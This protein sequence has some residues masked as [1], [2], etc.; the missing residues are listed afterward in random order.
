[1][2]PAAPWA[3]NLKTLKD[4]PEW[5]FLSKEDL[6]RKTLQIFADKKSALRNCRNNEKV[7]KIPNSKVFIL[8]GKFLISKG[9][10]RIVFEE[11]LIS[12]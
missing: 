8:S 7:L 11:N 3:Q 9:I 4:F 2:P 1:M 12:I 10:S 5:G 6:S